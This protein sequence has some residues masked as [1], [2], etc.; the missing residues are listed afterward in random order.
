[1]SRVVASSPGSGRI[2]RWG[3]TIRQVAVAVPVLAAALALP[4]PAGA[5]VRIGGDS[6]G[7]FSVPVMSWWEIPFRTVVRQ[8]YDFSCGSAALAT[9]LTY[10]YHRPTS[11]AATFEAMWRH[12]DQAKIR[13]AGFSMLDMK[14]YLNGIGLHAEGLRFTLGELRQLRRPAIA[15]MDIRG[16]KH[17]VVIKGVK[18]DRVLVGDPMLGLRE[19][20][21]D[22]FARQW[23]NI[24]VAILAKPEGT[25]PSFNL[26]SDWGPWSRAPLRKGLPDDSAQRLTS[27]LPQTYQFSPQLILDVRQTGP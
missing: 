21:L 18:G 13:K 25:S 23:N 15:L 2:R 19:Y 4:Q 10:H 24:L 12:G 20:A 1:M 22:D 8:R 26:A 6:N 9:L 11:E 27:Q 16:Y 17:F 3:R 7:Y 5:Q 14:A